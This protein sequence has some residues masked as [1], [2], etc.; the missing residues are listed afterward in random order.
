[1]GDVGPSQLAP[2]D[3]SVTVRQTSPTGRWTKGLHAA[4]GR[5][6]IGPTKTEECESHV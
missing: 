1:M 5:E 2:G 4:A 3:P 6:T